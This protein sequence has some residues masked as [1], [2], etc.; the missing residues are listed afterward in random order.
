MPLLQKKELFLAKLLQFM[1]IPD[2]AR[3]S[4]AM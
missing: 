2:S 3:D 1:L 4:A